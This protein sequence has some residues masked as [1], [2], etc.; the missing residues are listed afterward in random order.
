MTSGY[1]RNMMEPSSVRSLHILKEA[2]ADDHKFAETGKRN[3]EVALQLRYSALVEL[4]RSRMAIEHHLQLQRATDSLDLLLS[5][6]SELI[7][8]NYEHQACSNSSNICQCGF[9]S[10]ACWKDSDFQISRTCSPPAET[11]G[12]RRICSMCRFTATT[13]HRSQFSCQTDA[14][15]VGEGTYQCRI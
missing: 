10:G 1:G 11:V 3:F 4:L 13:S 8:Q 12:G 6:E 5:S 14:R 2:I 9:F 15:P 7:S